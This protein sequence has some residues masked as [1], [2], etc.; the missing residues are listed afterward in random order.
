[1]N[2]VVITTINKPTEAVFRLSKRN[3]IKTIVIGDNKTPKNWTHKNISFFSIE[4]QKKLGFTVIPLLPLNHYSRKI[5]GYLIAMSYNAD[6][7]IDLDDDN[8]PDELWTFPSRQDEINLITGFKGFFNAYSYFSTEKIWPRGFPLEQIK[9]NNKSTFITGSSKSIGIWQGLAN[10]DPDVDAIWR[11]T[12]ISKEFQ[13]DSRI[14]LGL[15]EGIAS[16][17]NSQNTLI[18]K[19]LF[20]LLY[21]PSTVTFRYTDIL[22]SLVA[23][24]IMWLMGYR[25][26]FVSANVYQARNY[27]NLMDDFVSEIPMYTNTK[28]MDYVEKSISPCNS[29]ADNLVSV[30]KRLLKE[31]VVQP[32]EI[33][34]LDAFLSDIKSILK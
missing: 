6:N 15:D 22:R 2:Y 31:S 8:Y 28:I 17:F 26:G 7:I 24:P 14:P 9:N 13:F 21:L 5:I 25:L 18:I 30:Y 20:P 1:M 11:L 27:H 23:Q 33:D 29:I 34:L 19:E 10:G 16:P 12:N 4:D 3:D 32:L